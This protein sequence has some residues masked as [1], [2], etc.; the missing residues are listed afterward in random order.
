M[1]QVSLGTVLV[2][3][4]GISLAAPAQQGAGPTS[5]T[6]VPTLIRF[7]GT[8]TDESG[9]PLT[10]ITGVTFLF[11]KDETGGAP[12]WLETQ[13]ITP[14][15]AGHYTAVLGST[16]SSGL[17]TDLFAS[18]KARWLG[19]QAQGQAEQPRVLLLSV[20]YALKAGD[21]QTVGGLPASA[22]VL[23]APP[24]FNSTPSTGGAASTSNSG[25]VIP[26]TSSDVTTTGGKVNAIPL[27]TT[28]TNIQNSIVT[29]TGAT[30]ISVAGKLNLPATGTATTTAGKNSQPG[31]FAASAYNSTTKAAVA[32]TFQ[33]QAEPLG[34]NTA[35]PSGTFNLLYGSGT[36][37]PA[38][39]GFKISNKGLLTFATGQTFPGVGTIT[40]VTAGTGLKGGGTTGAVTLNVDT[41]KIPL[42]AAA[43]AFSG[44]QTITGNLTDTG[45][46]SATGSVSSQTA[47]FSASN[48]TQTETV[49]QK[50]AGSAMIATTSAAATAY[51]PAIL[52]NSTSTTGYGVG[53]EGTTSGTSGFG[54]YGLATNA[55][56]STQG[57]GVTGVSYSPSGEGVFGLASSTA[58]GASATGVSGTSNAPNGTG[59]EGYAAGNGS[60]AGVFGLT[61]AVAG[62]GVH[63]LWSSASATGVNIIETGVWG[64]S[65]TGAGVTGTS[66]TYTGVIGYSNT[67][68]GVEGSS[69]ATG[70]YGQGS[71]GVYGFD[72]HIS[73]ILGIF[74]TSSSS[75]SGFTTMGVWGD[76][77]CANCFG[78]VGTSDNGNSF[79]GKNNTVNHE[80][81]YVENDSGFAN[82]MTPSAARFAGPG[83]S[84]YCEIV[85]DANDDG[86]GDLVCTGSKSAAV[87]AGRNR[88]V[89]LYAVEAAENWFEDAGSGQLANGT[90]GVSLD[91]VF[92]QT[93]NGELDYHVFLTPNG[94]C[95]GLY[96]TNKRSNSF[97]VH[98]LGGGHS[99]IAFD[100]RIMARRRGFERVRLQDVTADFAHAKAESAALAARLEAGKASDKNRPKLPTPRPRGGI[101]KPAAAPARVTMLGNL[102][103]SK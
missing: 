9:K 35:T 13:N 12:L 18:G 38:E 25:G 87:P 24:P 77:G 103:G 92:A 53:V 26:A 8:L 4:L 23:A 89:R 62:V 90:A 54:V 22:F 73:A 94:D 83:A 7:S 31:L 101:P 39:T 20:P 86:T 75:G 42:L 91:A 65:A 81:L 99:S 51:V 43:N 6:T 66:D 76:S 67:D 88:M 17:P 59:V 3:L 32:Q 36:A 45:N 97:E 100:Y 47:S 52:G 72:D 71:P 85:R 21:A 27:F 41:T 78:V 19:V 29:Q 57:I 96:V 44:N 80:T 28:A 10:A 16:T 30:A 95:K 61:S 60:G 69:N 93:V 74:G 33:L 50:G 11:Y 82:S 98:E 34:N 55:A 56:S 63:G 5:S 15:K 40:G 58:T 48:T 84:T 14:D 2:L 1:K 70:V 37:A 64:D 49:T 102:P 46:I 79:F 68:V